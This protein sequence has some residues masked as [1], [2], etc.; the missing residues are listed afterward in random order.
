MRF[1]VNI[2]FYLFAIANILLLISC[3]SIDTSSNTSTWKDPNFS[4]TISKVLIIGIHSDQ[5]ERGLYEDTLVKLLKTTGVQSVSSI[6]IFP[7]DKALSQDMISS[8]IKSDGFDSVLVT[9]V[10]N[11]ASDSR[12]ALT[13]R[14]FPVRAYR[15]NLY[16]FYNRSYPIVHS[17]N[18]YQ[19]NTTLSLETN[20]YSAINS[21]LVWSN[22]SGTFNQAYIKDVS[23]DISKSVISSLARDH[24][25][26]HNNL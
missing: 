13:R 12:N 10:I 24:L 9:R 14:N 18:Y 22:Q 2:I 6:S 23:D 17:P 8:I 15:R 26:S 25:I 4:T 19:S 16:D 21:S 5:E 20:L 7:R 11:E 1:H 3:A